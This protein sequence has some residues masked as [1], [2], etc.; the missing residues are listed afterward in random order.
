[1]WSNSS[2]KTLLAF[3]MNPA[4]IL[5]SNVAKAELSRLWTSA[6]VVVVVY[7]LFTSPLALA[8]TSSTSSHVIQQFLELR[9]FDKLHFEPSC[10]IINNNHPVFSTFLNGTADL[11]MVALIRVLR[12]LTRVRIFCTW[13]YSI[14]H[15]SSW[16]LDASTPFDFFLW[17][18]YEV[19]AIVGILPIFYHLMVLHSIFPRMFFRCSH[20]SISFLARFYSFQE[21]YLSD[22]I[23]KISLFSPKNTTD[24]K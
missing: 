8:H 16:S 4:T 11:I 23:H 10:G 9:M 14:R 5:V 3:F 12:A 1:M 18:C 21:G 24:K 17:I 20:R 2:A 7:Y 13:N 6:S 15:Y 22:Y 19:C